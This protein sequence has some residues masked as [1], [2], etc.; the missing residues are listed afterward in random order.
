LKKSSKKL[1]LP[2]G[3]FWIGIF[4]MRRAI[5]I[6]A[7][8]AIVLLNAPIVVVVIMSF[9][10]GAYL[11]F[12]PDGLSLH[13]YNSYFH[14]PRWML[15]TANSLRL[16]LATVAIATPIGVLGSF[17]LMRG[18][19]RWRR[20]ALLLVNTPLLLPG[21]VAAIG[22]YFFFARLG[23]IGSF[24]SILLAHVCLVVPI[25]VISV[26]AALETFD[27]NLERAA[28]GLGANRIRTFWWVTRPLIQPG[29]LTGMLFAFLLSFDELPVA[30]FLTGTDGATLP[31]RMWSNVR[32]EMDPTLAAV[33]TLLVAL[34]VAAIVAT[35]LL[36]SRPATG[37]GQSRSTK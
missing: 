29:I 2:A 18:K 5:C 28:A 34:C 36:Q 17:G 10:A 30:L 15:A 6:W 20:L 32:D 21:V 8:T 14:S 12:P 1:L 24:L 9:S 23:L 35:Q 13:W 3:A 26:N 7:W 25:V 4:Y 22:M 27:Q 31:V 16:A 33:S 19:F 37:T 11:S